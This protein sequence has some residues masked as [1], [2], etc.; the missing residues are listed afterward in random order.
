MTVNITLKNSSTSFS[1]VF[2]LEDTGAGYMIE[3]LDTKL[4]R[5]YP[6]EDVTNIEIEL[7]N[8]KQTK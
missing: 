6:Y 1:D 2:K 3:F 5:F 8:S 4:D 7:D